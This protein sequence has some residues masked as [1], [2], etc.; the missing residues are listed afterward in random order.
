MTLRFA[1]AAVVLCLLP[2]PAI[3]QDTIPTGVRV[4]LTYDPST[5]PG[6]FV[7]AVAGDVSDSVRTM[8]ARNLDFGDRLTIIS[9]EAGPAPTGKFNY[10]LYAK[11]GASAVVAASITRQGS[12]HVAV[13]DVAGKRVLNAGDFAF[14]GTAL[15]SPAWRM[16][17]HRASDEVERWITSTRGI[18]ATRIV[19]VRDQR[20]WVVDAD[21]ADLA[22]LGVGGIALSPAWHP[23]A[24]YIAYAQMADDGTHIVVRDITTGQARRIPDQGGTNITPAFSPDG[25]T[26]V[27]SAGD[28]GTDLFAVSPF[29]GDAPRRVTFGRGTPTSSPSFS[30]DGR[31]IAYISGRPG[32]PEVY[33]TDADG[34]NA[35]LLTESPSGDQP[36]RASPDWSPDGRFVAF[37]SQEGPNLQ[38]MVISMRDRRIRQLTGD[39]RNEDPSWAPDGR[40]VVFTSTRSGAKQ[41]WVLDTESGRT[42]QLTRGAGAARMAAWSPRME[43]P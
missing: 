8:L 29:G 15:F 42:R 32:H 36:Y 16:V 25:S 17:V 6:V 23:T 18:A 5:R 39:A 3:G 20:L 19:F 12:L 41:L 14:N 26:L 13:H 30:P 34:T 1:R 27:F 43:Q 28:D 37:T 22:P 10:E 40:H 9:A 35:E 24:R 7:A 11:L 33:I 38:V 4:G 31:K 21:G 2:L